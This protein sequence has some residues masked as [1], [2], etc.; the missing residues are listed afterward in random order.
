MDKAAVVVLV[1]LVA[2][3]QQAALQAPAA[4]DFP[5]QFRE[6][7]FSTL[8]VVVVLFIVQ[9]VVLAVLVVHLSAEMA[10]L[11]PLVAMEQLIEAAVVVLVAAPQIMQA[12][13][14]VLE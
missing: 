3:E 11:V 9:A 8:A 14:V 6:R 1:E 10:E 5:I 13:L 12:V 4:Q 7:L 2:Q